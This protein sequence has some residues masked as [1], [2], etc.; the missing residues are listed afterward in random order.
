MKIK[1]DHVYWLGQ[2]QT[3]EDQWEAIKQVGK[4]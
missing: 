1:F 2:P 3:I 4:G